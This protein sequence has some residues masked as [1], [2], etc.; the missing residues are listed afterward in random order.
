[1]DFG[2]TVKPLGITVKKVGKVVETSDVV[3]PQAT[4][5]YWKRGKSPGA[6][7]DPQK[8]PKKI[9]NFQN[10]ETFKNL[11]R[12]ASVDVGRDVFIA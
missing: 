5:E 10:F 4:R 8:G 12:G 7:N 9:L 3:K 2:P 11:W 6:Q 1:M